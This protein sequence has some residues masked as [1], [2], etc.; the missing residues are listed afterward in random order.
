MEINVPDQG[1]VTDVDISYMDIDH[2]W[3]SDL[4]VALIAPSGSRTTVFDRHCGSADNILLNLNQQSNLT[5]LP[6]PPNSDGR[7]IRPP[8]GNLSIFND[9]AGQGTWELEVSDGFR[10]DGGR[11][12]DVAIKICFTNFAPLPVELIEFTAL[13]L[14]NQ[15][16]L[17]WETV[18]EEDNSGFYVERSSASSSDWEELGFVPATGRTSGRYAFTDQTVRAGIDYY[19]RLRQVDV[20]GRVEYSSIRSAQLDRRASSISL[21]PNPTNGLINYSW[22]VE[23][24]EAVDYEIYDLRG[25]KVTSGEFQPRGGQLDLRS[26]AIGVY[27]LKIQSEYAVE[28]MRIVKK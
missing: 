13:P 19:Y 25:V 7:F 8:S 14:N 3:V 27:L 17:D 5:T 28:T 1:T 20:D 16:Q 11:M 26:L 15:I 22:L 12:N 10:R 2:S 24:D 4:R 6:C 23:N 18:A 21:A 9:Q